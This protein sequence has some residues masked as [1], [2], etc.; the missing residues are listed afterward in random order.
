MTNVINSIYKE[1]LFNCC[2]KNIVAGHVLKKLFIIHL[3]RASIEQLKIA[4]SQKC[5]LSEA[6]TRSILENDLVINF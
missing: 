5:G 4:I 2:I 3:V 6:A 1:N